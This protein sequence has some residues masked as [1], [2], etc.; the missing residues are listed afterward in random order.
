VTLETAFNQDRSNACFE[1]ADS[2]GVLIS[3]QRP[4]TRQQQPTE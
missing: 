4:M 3:P 1:K 2:L